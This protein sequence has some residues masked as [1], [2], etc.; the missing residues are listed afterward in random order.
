MAGPYFLLWVEA[1]S[2]EI[3]LSRPLAL[4]RS[5][6][7]LGLAEALLNHAQEAVLAQRRALPWRS[8]LAVGLVVSREAEDHFVVGRGE[9][10]ALLG[11]DEVLL[12]AHHVHLHDVVGFLV[13]SQDVADV[14]KGLDLS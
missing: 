6:L 3:Q 2:S 13:V 12:V 4:L 10:F 7:H 14:L 9:G 1:G 8:G 11:L 5:R